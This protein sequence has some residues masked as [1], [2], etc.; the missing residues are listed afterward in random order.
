MKGKIW[1]RTVTWEEISAAP[2]VLHLPG[3]DD[4]AAWLGQQST[5][6]V[7]VLEAGQAVSEGAGGRGRAMSMVGNLAV[8]KS[9]NRLG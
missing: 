4:E 6:E 3:K 1:V 9:W 2:D 7:L 8:I 5:S